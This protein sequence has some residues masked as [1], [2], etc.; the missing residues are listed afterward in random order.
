[1]RPLAASYAA[2][3]ARG[4]SAREWRP[5]SLAAAMV[6]Y[7]SSPMDTLPFR[8]Q[9]GALPFDLAHQAAH[10]G[11]ADPNHPLKIESA[12][13]VQIDLRFAAI[14]AHKIGRASCRERVCQ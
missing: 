4:S 9:R 13:P 2:F 10:V 7:R 11:L 8:N 14:A 5:L 3:E 6:K 1:M 12:R